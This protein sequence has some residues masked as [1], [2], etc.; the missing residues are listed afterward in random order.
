MGVKA[1][2]VVVAML[3]A[4]IL[5][6]TDQTF[7]SLQM[8]GIIPARWWI[9]ISAAVG[10]LPYDTFISKKSKTDEDK[11]MQVLQSLG[12][13]FI[14][15]QISINAVNTAVLSSLGFQHDSAKL[16]FFLRWLNVQ[17]LISSSATI[18]CLIVGMISVIGYDCGCVLVFPVCIFIC[19]SFPTAALMIYGF[20]YAARVTT[21]MTVLNI[22]I[23]VLSIASYASIYKKVEL[24]K[25]LSWPV[26]AFVSSVK[27][28]ASNFDKF[29]IAAL[30]GSSCLSCAYSAG[31]CATPSLN[32]TLQVACSYSDSVSI[33]TLVEMGA[34][35]SC[36]CQSYG[37]ALT[38]FL[39]KSSSWGKNSTLLLSSSDNTAELLFDGKSLDAPA[40]AC[41]SSSAAS[42]VLGILVVTTVNCFPIQ[43]VNYGVIIGVSIASTILA[44]CFEV[45]T[46]SIED[47]FGKE[48]DIEEA[49]G[50]T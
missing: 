8:Q 7:W 20:V 47:T 26:Q 21:L 11:T 34:G 46:Y 48:E 22:S 32:T 31:L 15:M 4:A 19:I 24:K 10:S 23:S 18:L 39:N 6:I 40:R 41:F 3:A 42:Q 49:T 37:T 33:D 50:Q 35:L 12:F 28:L 29:V 17:T 36:P 45:C 25:T 13:M 2:A 1:F 9:I 5:V 44:I 30:L 27:K 16:S 38:S 14:G 43:E